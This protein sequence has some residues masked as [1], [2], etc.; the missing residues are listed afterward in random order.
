[1]TLPVNA[2]WAQYSY[3][4]FRLSLRV[5]ERL[6]RVR[7][8]VA[9]GLAAHQLVARHQQREWEMGLMLPMSG[10]EHP[11]RIR[12]AVWWPVQCLSMV[13]GNRSPGVMVRPR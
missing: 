6:P 12:A 5:V 10:Q 3:S 13:A 7:H 4:D 11:A 1:M 8:V 9:R 2:R